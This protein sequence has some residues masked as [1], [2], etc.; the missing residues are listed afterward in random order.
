MPHIFS[1]AGQLTGTGQPLSEI[2]YACGFRDYVHFARRFRKR[3][4]YSPGAHA[5]RGRCARS[6][7]RKCVLGTRRPISDVLDTIGMAAVRLGQ[8]AWRATFRPSK[9]RIAAAQS[10]QE[11]PTGGVRSNITENGR[12]SR[13]TTVGSAQ[14]DGSR[15]RRP[16]VLPERGNSANI[17]RCSGFIWRIPAL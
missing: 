17:R 9:F 14:G 10:S 3:F 15:P 16:P 4:G 12:I 7:R 6:Y 13:S 8:R 2:A 11:Q 5:G 1:T